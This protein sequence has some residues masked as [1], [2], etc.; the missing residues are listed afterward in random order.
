MD[1]VWW[2]LLALVAVVVVSLVALYNRLRRL[3][4]GVEDARVQ[5]HAQLEHRH[6]LIRRLIATVESHMTH[7][8]DALDA[9]KA[10]Y[11]A[12]SEASGAEEQARGEDSLNSALGHLLATV[13]AD[14]GLQADHDF[15]GLRAELSDT[16]GQIEFAR[17][18]YNER[19]LG[20]DAALGAFPSSLVAAAL[21]FRPRPSGP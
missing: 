10:A 8:Q 11:T 12:A 13:K 19:V 17:R 6:D 21:G 20:Y 18:Y 7:E 1:L 5:M 3:H 9:A 15:V 14:S 4:K 2:V 16:E